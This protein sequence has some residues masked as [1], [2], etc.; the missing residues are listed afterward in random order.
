M[1]INNIHFVDIITKKSILKKNKKKEK[2]LFC[3]Y[4]CNTN[5]MTC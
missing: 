2:L 1:C 3:N 4:T 5:E